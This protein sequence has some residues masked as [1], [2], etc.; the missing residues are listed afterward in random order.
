VSLNV[1]L[2][3]PKS[4][5]TKGFYRM[6]ASLRVAHPP[7]GVKYVFRK[8]S[9]RVPPKFD[10]YQFSPETFTF[11]LTNALFD[12]LRT[13]FRGNLIHSFFWSYF[14]L[15]H[16]WIHENDSSLSQYLSGYFNKRRDSSNRFIKLAASILNAHSCKK[17]IV[18][19]E[20][21]RNGMID[22]GVNEQKVVVI[23]PPIPT[24]SRSSAQ[25][26]RVTITFVGRDYERKGGDLVVRAFGDL[27]KRKDVH[28]NY[29]GSIDDKGLREYVRNNPNITYHEFLFNGNLH[30]EVFPATDVL[31]LPTRAEAF[32][33][34]VLEAMSYG[35]PVLASDLTVIKE[36]LNGYS[37]A[38]TF[39]KD[40]YKE[41]V[42]KLEFMVE[43]ES[44]R[45]TIGDGL[46]RIVDER[47]KPAVV[48]Q[49]LAKTYNECL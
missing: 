18:W 4:S 10:Q 14:N 23:P 45:R 11:W 38:C 47:Y 2:V 31:V 25:K 43:N 20:H 26:D 36:L 16:P 30:R 1:T 13:R 32:G 29:V 46:K 19:S 28:L 27:E 17:V 7:P 9:F 24:R 35:I 49:K 15:W 5:V 40:N 21:A 3:A 22:D 44:V 12:H 8:S 39:E 41:F 42:E 6:G 33:L 37:D 48:N 34:T